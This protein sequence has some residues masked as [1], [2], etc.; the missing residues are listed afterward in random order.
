MCSVYPVEVNLQG[1]KSREENQNVLLDS[2]PAASIPDRAKAVWPWRAVDIHTSDSTECFS[3]CEG[4]D[5]ISKV[6]M[7]VWVE[8]SNIEPPRGVVR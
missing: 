8:I 5:Q 1:V 6:Q 2:R 7:F 4:G 3:F